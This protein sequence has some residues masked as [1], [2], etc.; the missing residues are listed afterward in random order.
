M[1]QAYELWFKQILHDLS[2][3]IPLFNKERVDE[4]SMNTVVQR[5][6]RVVL[7]QKLLLDQLTILETM[8]PLDFLDF[9][10]LLY[11][12]SGF[13]SLQFRT[14]ENILGLKSKDRLTY[15][16]A[17]Y[18][19]H[20]PKEQAQ[21]LKHIESQDSLFELIDRW[22][23]RTPFLKLKGFDFW[24]EYEDSVKSMF[25]R[26]REII[27]NNNLLDENSKQQNYK[28]IE[29]SE[30]L[31][32]AIFNEEEY[33][34]LREQGLWRLSYGA[35]HGALLVQLYRHLPIF[36]LPFRLITTLLDIDENMTT[37]RYRHALM[38]QRML[39][40]KVGTGGSSGAQYLKQSTEQH[41][42]FKD[43]FQLTTFFLPKSELPK[44][45]EEL[46]K[47]FGFYYES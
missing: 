45:P 35:I 18:E 40:T 34:N 26:E 13:Q 22:L 4:S 28:I 7:T 32:S 20:F 25:L 33:N 47:Q 31:F 39:G 10:D 30:Q 5:L 21:Q 6:E 27:K 29:G 1:H 16:K 14:I 3:V 44:M 46:K 17:S 12:A 8:T 38:A 23:A 15:N 9:R 11:P 36:H 41:K 43:F 42:I 24:K 19:S 2:S 37:W